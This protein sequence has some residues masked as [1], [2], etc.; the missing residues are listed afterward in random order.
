MDEQ[1]ERAPGPAAPSARDLHAPVRSIGVHLYAQTW[2]GVLSLIQV[3]IL[4]VLLWLA[5]LRLYWAIPQGVFL[6][7]STLGVVLVA[8]G[9][10]VFA[11]LW[12]RAEREA[13]RAGAK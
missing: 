3:T 5:T 13:R 10:P 7:V 9:V 11:V 8:G 6:G 2:L 12:V 4:T 1:N